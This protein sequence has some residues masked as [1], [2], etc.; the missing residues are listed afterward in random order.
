MTVFATFNAPSELLGLCGIR[1]SPYLKATVFSVANI[2]AFSALN[3]IVC[4]AFASFVANLVAF[5]TKLLRA[6]EG[7]VTIFTTEDAVK[8]G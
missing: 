4:T 6:V 1:S 5:K 7:I 8:L 3:D 2:L